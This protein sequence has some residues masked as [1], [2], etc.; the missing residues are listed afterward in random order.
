MARSVH[1]LTDMN[2]TMR[3]TPRRAC[4]PEFLARIPIPLAV[5]LALTSPAFAQPQ[6]PP[7]APSSDEVRASV[8]RSAERYFKDAPQA[9]ALSI[10]VFKDGST[11]IYNFG[12][13][14]RNKHDLP[15]ADTLYPIASI[16][17]TFTGTLL[18][19]AALEGRLQLTD[20]VRKYLDGA[21][22]NLEYEGH[23]IELQFLVNHIS[24]LPF[25]LPDIPGN[26]PP[27]APSMS[28][29]TLE[30]VNHYTRADFLRDLHSVK[31]TSVPGQKFSYSNAGAEL[32]SLVL[33]RV[34][35]ES[36]EKLM[37]QKIAAPLGMKDTT[38]SLTRSQR[39]R[40]APGYD[41]DGEVNFEEPIMA[42]GAAGLQSTVSDL[43][44]YAAWETAED[45]AAVKISHEPRLNPAPDYSFGLN[46]QMIR[47]GE[48]VRIW[49]DGSV[50]GF[51]SFCIMFPKL[52][53]AIVVLTNELD[54]VTSKAFD[55]IVP[56]IAES[57]DPRSS[58]LF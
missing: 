21:Y 36:Y 26:R 57:I 51:L 56:S 11:Y 24:G 3:I 28:A 4:R 45:D 12:S 31:L 19:Q 8:T 41:Q 22:P 53:M 33:E 18:A 25:N 52:H 29:K 55:A 38:I 46:W 54:P 16:T 58:A 13:V 15:S 44:K 48:A 2:Q 39:Q 1:V 17:K 49:E 32:L 47:R 9:V 37:Q 50:P 40:L 35:G 23:P 7:V 5:F 20:D 42:L 43:L 14:H 10:G 34:Y 6:S 30:F 27:F